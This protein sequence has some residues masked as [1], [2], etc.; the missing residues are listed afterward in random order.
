MTEQ[1]KIYDA[2][3]DLWL[4]GTRPRL[5]STHTFSPDIWKWMWTSSTIIIGN[6]TEDYKQAFSSDMVNLIH[7]YMN[8]DGESEFFLSN[9]TTVDDMR[10]VDFLN[11][12]E[13]IGVYF[14]ESVSREVIRFDDMVDRLWFI[15][16]EGIGGNILVSELVGKDGYKI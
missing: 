6:S 2:E 16:P 12:M 11:L 10:F 1:Y 4:Y 9:A 15:N 3:H 5:V 13:A 8:G 7:E 14:G